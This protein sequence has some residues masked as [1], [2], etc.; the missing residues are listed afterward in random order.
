MSKPQIDSVVVDSAVTQITVSGSGFKP[1][2]TAPQVRFD[3]TVLTVTSSSDTSFVASLPSGLTSGSYELEVENSNSFTNTEAFEVSISL[4][5][6][7]TNFF[8]FAATNS[9]GLYINGYITNVSLSSTPLVLPAIGAALPGSTIYDGV[10]K[11]FDFNSGYFDNLR[12]FISA[13]LPSSAG[14]LHI[15]FKNQTTNTTMVTG[16]SEDYFVIS[17]GSVTNK[18]NTNPETAAGITNFGS[19]LGYNQE[20]NDV[21]GAPPNDQMLITLSVTGDPIVVP[22]VTWHIW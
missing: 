3:G 18:G 14:D 9:S 15:G 12:V 4:P 1:S 2:T 7:S 20:G 21:Y 11:G 6:P 13:P 5:T 16:F 8:S 22:A 17:N 19:A 10:I